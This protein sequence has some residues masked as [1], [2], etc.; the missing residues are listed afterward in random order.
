MSAGPSP[1]AE[2][3]T[4]TP[5]TTLTI[6]KLAPD[7]QEVTRYRGQVLDRAWPESWVGARAI[8]TNRAV[9]VDGLWFRPG[10]R[11]DEFFSSA[12]WFN[13]FQVVAPTGEARGWYANVTYPARL[14]PGPAGLTLVWHDLYVDVVV[15]ADGTVAIRDEDELAASALAE[16]AP[17]IHKKI[18][19]TRDLILTRIASRTFPFDQ[20]EG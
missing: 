15:L 17:E 12:E 11:L 3:S 2:W 9:A 20:P 14:E 19:A 6:V 1:P 10:D 18:M 13:A 4:L 7:G 8:W 16:R 5:G